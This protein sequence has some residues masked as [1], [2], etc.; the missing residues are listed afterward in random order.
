MGLQEILDLF[1][2]TCLEELFALSHN[3]IIRMINSVEDEIFLIENILKAP[4]TDSK[5]FL[6]GTHLLSYEINCSHN[7]NLTRKIDHPLKRI[8]KE[9]SCNDTRH[10]VERDDRQGATKDVG[11]I[12][13]KKKKVQSLHEQMTSIGYS[14]LENIPE[15]LHI[16][17]D[18]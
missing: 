7:N 17:K 5:L 2:H 12:K 10:E 16:R 13:I 18:L 15:H 1:L 3:N 14:S 8:I 6:L 4:T 9:S 11:G